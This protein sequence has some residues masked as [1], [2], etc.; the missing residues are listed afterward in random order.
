MIY[1][2]FVLMFLPIINS[3]FLD[4][5]RITGKATSGTTSVNITVGNTPPTIISV[6]NVSIIT[7]TITEAGSTQFVF[8][9]TAEDSDGTG[10]I[11][12]SKAMGQI[13][14]TSEA[15]RSNF[16]CLAKTN[17]STTRTQFECTTRIWYF[18][19][20][21]IWTINAT[22][23]DRGGTTALNM[24]ANLTIKSTLAMVMGPSSLTWPTIN[25]S[26]LNTTAS[27]DPI[28][29]NNT[30]NQNVSLGNVR[31]QALDLAGE[32][33]PTVLLNASNFTVGIA[34]G[35]NNPECA[36]TRLANNT[37]VGIS[38]VGLISGNNSLAYNNFTSGQNTLYFCLAEVTAGVTQQS[39]STRGAAW[40]IS[41]V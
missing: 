37:I 5:F 2:L 24:S 33:T 31:V 22:V 38:R 8:N 1:L 34:T 6:D 15:I 35:T 29:L 23:Q 10:D 36:D 11:V 16:S 9:F 18:D 25:L 4:F 21:G 14:R 12:S 30:G 40:T 27:D 28:I 17:L 41:V 26:A 13:N 19:A 20:P 32:T 3:S 39:Y 7:P